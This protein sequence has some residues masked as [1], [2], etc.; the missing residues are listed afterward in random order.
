VL[1]VF[2]ALVALALALLQIW[3]S[4]FAFLVGASNAGSVDPRTALVSWHAYGEVPHV[5]R[6]LLSSAQLALGVTLGVPLFIVLLPELLEW[7]HRLALLGTP[8]VYGETH[9]ARLAEIRRAGLLAGTGIVL[10]RAGGRLLCFEGRERGKNV[11]IAAAPGS[12]KTAGIMLPNCLNWPQSL[13]ALDIKGD[14]ARRTADFRRGLGQEVHVLEFSARAGAGAQYNPFAYVSCD[15]ERRSGDV[16]KIAR[17]LCPDTPTGDPFWTTS[18]RE[19]FRALA[20]YLY[21]IGEPVTLGAIR[22][23][24]EAGDGLRVFAHDVLRDIRAGI[25]SNISPR[26]ARDFATVC[27]RSDNTHSGIVDQLMVALA[28]LSDP[29]VRRTTSQNSFDL[30]ALRSRPMTVY[31]VAA[32]PDLP[33]LRPLV[34]LFFQQ[35][36][37]QNTRVEF[38]ADPRHCS[39]VLLA[40]DEFAQAGRLD[41]ILHGITYFRSFGLRLLAIVQSPAQLKEVY[42]FDAAQSFEQ[43]FDCRVYFTPAA[44]DLETAETVSRLLGTNTLDCAPGTASGPFSSPGRAGRAARSRGS[45]RAGLRARALLLP[46]EVLRLRLDREIVLLGGVAPVLAEKIRVWRDRRFRGR[47]RD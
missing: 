20:L 29:L 3:S 38:G 28:P 5:H 8:P 39:E 35:L 44:S 12:G 26:V 30:R 36:V 42:S 46:Q 40:M 7:G 22:D 6:A 11:M 17:Y 14:C 19:L 2:V 37:D 32:R 34:N 4:L 41:A 25:L 21:D 43:A 47:L 15:P 45:G 24:L 31:V 23:L 1:I 13:V 9:W 33:A 16:E 18:A 10:G 27:A